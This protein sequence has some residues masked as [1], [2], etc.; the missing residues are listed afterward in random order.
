MGN[1]RQFDEKETR[2]II[3]KYRTDTL[4]F[5]TSMLDDVLKQ[6]F[7]MQEKFK[8]ESIKAE[9]EKTINPSNIPKEQNIFI[10]LGSGGRLDQA[11]PKPFYD[12]RS[13]D[14]SVLNILIGVDNPMPA[15][16]A[17]G[18]ETRQELALLIN[19]LVTKSFPIYFP[20]EYI[21]PT[22][23][24]VVDNLH[25]WSTEKQVNDF[26]FQWENYLIACL[27][28]GKNLILG[29][30]IDGVPDGY[31]LE[32]YNK[33]KEQY[34]NQL[35]LLLGH[36]EYAAVPI[37]TV[38]KEQLND[39]HNT[40]ELRKTEPIK[41]LFKFFEQNVKGLMNDQITFENLRKWSAEAMSKKTVTTTDNKHSAAAGY[42]PTT[43]KSAPASS[44]GSAT[45]PPKKD[46]DDTPKPLAAKK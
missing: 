27:K 22:G 40:P 13:R 38:T 17:P 10:N 28:S 23:L 45:E 25:P 1:Q 20:F 29:Y 39:A 42:N 3:R 4:Q 16:I 43:F 11:F 44:G 31:F 18:S 8:Y 37:G 36:E 33:L 14:E 24:E 19:K 5:T 30:H 15:Q 41:S 26:K 35:F 32:V 21:A 12:A 46:P 9:L 2:D 7:D 6:P 34:P